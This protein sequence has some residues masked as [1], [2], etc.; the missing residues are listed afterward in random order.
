MSIQGQ[1]QTVV[2]AAYAATHRKDAAS[3]APSRSNAI[4][5]AMSRPRTE[6]KA[7]CHRDQSALSRRP[8]PSFRAKSSPRCKPGRPHR[9]RDQQRQSRNPDRAR[10][11]I[12]LP[13]GWP[14]RNRRRLPK[15]STEGRHYPSVKL[16]D[17][18]FKAQSWPTSSTARTTPTNLIDRAVAARTAIKRC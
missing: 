18:S 13:L 2:Q 5:A 10:L 7:N 12:A 1:T 14:S 6:I 4:E 15:R 17:P 11:L 3:I 8:M 9:P 16:D